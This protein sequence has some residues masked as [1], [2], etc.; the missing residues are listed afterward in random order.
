MSTAMPVPAP[1]RWEIAISAWR[2]ASLNE[3]LRGGPWGAARLK[4]LDREH[5]FLY[6]RLARV[7]HAVG[8]RRVSLRITLPP[9]QR[10]WDIDA[11]WKSLLDALVKASMLRDDNPKWCEMGGVEYTRGEELSTTIILEEV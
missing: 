1:L 5:V 3:L 6:S 11:L 2:P 8:K 7:P 4:R 10:R 9:K